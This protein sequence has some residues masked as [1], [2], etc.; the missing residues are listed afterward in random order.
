M[1]TFLTD[2]RAR[3]FLPL[4][5]MLLLLSPMA[6]AHAADPP[7]PFGAATVDDFLVAC[8]INQGSCS[9]AV[10]TALLSNMGTSPGAICLQSP[11]YAQRIP[12]WLAAH[13]ETFQM[14]AGDGIYVALKAL[15]PC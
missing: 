14:T 13:P 12:V 15:Y 2:K 10:G 8:R 9:A 3:K 6:V 11:D 1:E 7:S 5:G 4:G